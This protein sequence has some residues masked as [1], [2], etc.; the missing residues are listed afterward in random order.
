MTKPKTCAAVP[1]L[2]SLST[3]LILFLFCNPMLRKHCESEICPN[4][5]FKTQNEQAKSPGLLL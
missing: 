5:Y 1:I 2:G 3:C 4:S